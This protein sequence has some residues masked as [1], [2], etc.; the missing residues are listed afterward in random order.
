MLARRGGATGPCSDGGRFEVSGTATGGPGLS[1]AGFLDTIPDGQVRRLLDSRVLALLNAVSGCEVGGPR[2]RLAVQAMVDFSALLEEASSRALVLGLLSEPKR[3]ELEHRLGKSVLPDAVGTW[4]KAD[5]S[6]LRA[7]FGLLEEDL[8]VAAPSAAPSE[9]IAPAYGLFDHQRVAVRRLL[10]LLAEDERRA[11]LHFPTGA[12]KTRTAM[13]VV[14]KIL[15]DDEPSVVVWLASGRELL[16]QAMQA[17]KEAWTHLGT[18]P[19]QLGTMWGDKKP[20]LADFTDGFLVA[21][22]AKGW[23]VLSRDDPDWAVRLA[24][25]VRLVVFDEA[26]QST[27]Q[28]YRR[29][30]DDLTLDYRCALLGLTAT[31]GR[32]WADIDKDGELA[33]LYSRTKVALEAPGGGNPVKYLIETGYLARPSFRTLL[34]EPGLK[35]DERE[36][37]RIATALEIP[38]RIV[39]TLS[40]SEKYVAAVLHA[41]EDLLRA[42]H[43]RVLVFGASV[44]HVHLLTGIL[45]A[46]GIRSGAVTGVTPRRDRDQAIR[47]FR[48]DDAAP[49]VLVNFGVLTT[50]FDAPLASAVVVARPTQSLVLFSQMVGRAIRG[51]R[52]GGTRACEIVT[53]VDPSLPGFG[54]VAEAFLN[55]EDVW[56]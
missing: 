26:H 14:A 44:D 53:V 11:V 23:A 32:T 54:D 37:A 17:F 18:R 13:H 6:G 41:V 48:A 28:T 33:D 38:E 46:R 30:T 51:E 55:W 22:L 42:G 27:A 16:E 34:A 21:G 2:L 4:T 50:G 47:S 29:L 10:P 19:L 45:V 40:M 24:P 52:V 12:G 1:I 5:V 39:T 9:L 36:A 49:R 3:V 43:R 56:Q 35:I 15:R 20:E 25:R 7:F 31:P 8:E